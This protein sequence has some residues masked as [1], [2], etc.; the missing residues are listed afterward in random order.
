MTREEFLAHV[1]IHPDQVNVWYNDD[2]PPYIVKAIS[3]PV[4]DGNYQNISNYLTLVQHIT[5]PLPQGGVVTL[6]I[7]ARQLVTG[8]V[9]GNFITCYL[10]DTTPTTVS[11]IYPISESRN[12]QLL[13]A[14]DDAQFED[15]PYNVLHGSIEELRT[16]AYIMQSDRYK[17][18]TLANPTYTGPLNIALLLSG[19][20]SL[21][22]VQDSNYTAT[23]WI[24]GRYEG[25]KTDEIRYKTSPAVTGVIFQGAEFPAS[26]STSEINYAQQSNQL[27]YKNYFSAGAGSTPGFDTRPSGYAVFNQV[28]STDTTIIIQSISGTGLLRMPRAGDFYQ[29]GSEIVKVEEAGISTATT[30]P[31]YTLVVIRGYSG[32]AN[33]YSSGQSVNYVQQV[34]IYNMTGDKLQGVPKG[35]VV[36]KETGVSVKL[37]ALGYI[38]SA[39]NVLQW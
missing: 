18:G 6:T 36:V 31:I 20:A 5:L 35:Q 3:V 4:I 27:V 38:V 7:T 33:A 32:T 16:S 12:L 28:T 9:N 30:P 26:A 23:G 22:H 17:I 1:Q 13:P 15:S 39:S 21:A 2:A 14:I 34:Q 37:D 10:L 24:N 11:Q 25:S 29:I 8:T 19:S